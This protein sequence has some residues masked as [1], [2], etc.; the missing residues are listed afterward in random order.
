MKEQ[1]LSPSYSG[2]RLPN[3]YVFGPK[4]ANG[5]TCDCTMGKAITGDTIN[6]LIVTPFLKHYI[7]LP[8]IKKT[9]NL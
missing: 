1:K 3:V 2:Q 9:L 5:V 4:E 7:T 6:E 8:L